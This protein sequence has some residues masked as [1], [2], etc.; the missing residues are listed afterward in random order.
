MMDWTYVSAYLLELPLKKH[1]GA[2]AVA[3]FKQPSTY[4]PRSASKYF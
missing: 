4:L 2:A 3:N 1:L